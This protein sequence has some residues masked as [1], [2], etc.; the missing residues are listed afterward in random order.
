MYTNR[1]Y[2]T[3]DYELVVGNWKTK[4][5]WTHDFLTMKLYMKRKVGRYGRKNRSNTT[6]QQIRLNTRLEEGRKK[7]VYGLSAQNCIFRSGGQWPTAP[8]TYIAWVNDLPPCSVTII[9]L[10]PVLLYHRARVNSRFVFCCAFSV[11]RVIY[12]FFIVFLFIY[13]CFFH[14]GTSRWKKNNNNK[15][16]IN[17]NNSKN[18]ILVDK[19]PTMSCRRRDEKNYRNCMVKLGRFV[20]ERVVQIYIKNPIYIYQYDK[21]SSSCLWELY[22]PTY[23]RFLLKHA[24]LLSVRSDKSRLIHWIRVVHLQRTRVL[25]KVK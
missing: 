14:I 18:H 23:M 9:L 5:Y 10:L 22:L 15:E 25:Y 13:L 6:L 4:R 8:S 1:S 2:T 3:G 17:N 21:G 7:V 20:L 19:F 12:F 24:I 11:G 16:L